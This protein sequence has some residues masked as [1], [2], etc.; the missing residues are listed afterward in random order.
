M[1]F[2]WRKAESWNWSL[3]GVKAFSFGLPTSIQTGWSCW[4]WGGWGAPWPLCPFVSRD[5]REEEEGE[6]RIWPNFHKDDILSID[7]YR[8]NLV[9]TASY[10]GDVKVWSLETGHVFCVLNANDYGAASRDQQIFPLELKERV[11]RNNAGPCKIIR[12][13]TF[14][15][16][17]STVNSQLLGHFAKIIPIIF[18]QLRNAI[19][20]NSRCFHASGQSGN[21]HLVN[22]GKGE[23][24]G[25][26][27][28]GGE[29]R[30]CE[31]PVQGIV[32]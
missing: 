4:G 31:L 19:I 21:L 30:V 22:I 26:G 3:L 5:C 20:Y 12:G 1:Y 2:F 23:K 15:Q 6:P 28:G 10:D 7:L 14:R 24:I 29:S 32:A 25:G 27:G 16:L 8:P 13:W 17:Q 18:Y 11:S 9:A